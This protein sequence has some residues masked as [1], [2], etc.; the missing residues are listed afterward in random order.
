MVKVAGWF[1]ISGRCLGINE[2]TLR[3]MAVFDKR[4]Q[5]ASANTL[6]EIMSSATKGLMDYLVGNFYLVLLK[7]KREENRQMDDVFGA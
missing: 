7:K 1:P 6:F 5:V 4:E 3:N 2:S